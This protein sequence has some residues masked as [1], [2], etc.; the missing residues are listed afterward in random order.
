[1]K[2]FKKLALLSLLTFVLS[3]FAVAQSAYNATYVIADGTEA[4]T[5]IIIGVLVNIAEEISSISDTIVF[6][7]VMNL[8]ALAIGAVLL[9]R[10]RAG[11]VIK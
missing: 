8:F 5:D 4:G 10:N 11:K 3:Q 1:M 2:G 7:V 9:V 6:V